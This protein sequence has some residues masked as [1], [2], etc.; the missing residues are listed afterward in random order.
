MSIFF[1]PFFSVHFFFFLLFWFSSHLSRSKQQADKLQHTSYSSN[2]KT[3]FS[4]VKD[5]VRLQEQ[6]HCMGWIE[7]CQSYVVSIG[8]QGKDSICE[9]RTAQKEMGS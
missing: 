8:T 1:F 2:A 9:R 6:T 7:F 4:L 3:L 5:C